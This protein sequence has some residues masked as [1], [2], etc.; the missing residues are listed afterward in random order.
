MMAQK[1]SWSPLLLRNPRPQRMSGLYRA[2]RHESGE[3]ECKERPE[4]QCSTRRWPES[5]ASHWLA[6][7]QSSAT[8][9]LGS[10]TNMQL[11]PVDSTAALRKSGYKYSSSTLSRTGIRGRMADADARGHGSQQARLSGGTSISCMLMPTIFQ[12]NS[13]VRYT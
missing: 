11:D 3:Q 9:F 8:S 1:L 5:V 2:S 12:G 6:V 7:R 4:R 10:R 13:Q